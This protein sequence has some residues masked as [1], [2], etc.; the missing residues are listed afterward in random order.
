MVRREPVR[1]PEV[2][3][4][5]RA[6]FVERVQRYGPAIELVDDGNPP[7]VHRNPSVA[8]LEALDAGEP[9]EVYMHE[10]AKFLTPQ[11]KAEHGRWRVLVDGTI[12]PVAQSK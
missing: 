3:A 5:L 2:R 12:E 6:K 4:A 7:L 8:R 11:E 10:I 9:V 1:R